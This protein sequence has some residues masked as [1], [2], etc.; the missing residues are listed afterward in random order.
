M[1]GGAYM[2]HIHETRDA[3][4]HFIINATTREIS[5]ADELPALVQHDH[6]SEVFTFVI[7]RYVD[8]HDMATCNKTRVHYIN[9]DSSTKEQ[10]ADL[11]EVKDLHV[12][13]T[14]ETKVVCTW[15][16]SRNATQ[17]AGVLNFVLQYT[18]ENDGVIDYAWNTA[19]FKGITVKNG[20]NNAEQVIEDYSD[21]LEAW[22]QE[23]VI[24]SG[25]RIQ[26]DHNQNDPTQPDYIKNRLAYRNSKFTDIVAQEYPEPIFG[27]FGVEEEN[28]ETGELEFYGDPAWLKISEP[29]ENATS[30]EAA[31]EMCGISFD[32][33]EIRVDD[34]EI[35]PEMLEAIEKKEYYS[36]EGE[37]LGASWGFVDDFH[38]VYFFDKDEVSIH[39]PYTE[40]DKDTGAVYEYDMIL[41]FPEKGVYSLIID[42][43]TDENGNEIYYG[44]DKILFGGL[45][46]I[47]KEFLPPEAL[48]P[49]IEVDEY[50]TLGSY[51]P[52]SSNAVAELGGNLLSAGV[53]ISDLEQDVSN[54]NTVATNAFNLADRISEDFVKHLGNDVPQINNRISAIEESLNNVGSIVDLLN[55]ITMLESKVF[56]LEKLHN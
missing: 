52:V 55:R 47:D 49:T 46:R 30:L 15:L 14:D 29:I 31:Q 20:I 24:L 56:N 25:K 1:K 2:A 9:I 40:T 6:N 35:P 5:N 41:F 36:D 3:E 22:K 33:E 11:Y 42:G 16:I 32:G 27:L 7:P 48:T 13:E 53:R 18:C 50:A 34:P 10:Y 19:I 21:I 44:F 37:L 28:E 39:I 12:D 8:G 45:K 4:T 26:A 54:A 17:Y 43:Y 51:N 23:L 38:Y